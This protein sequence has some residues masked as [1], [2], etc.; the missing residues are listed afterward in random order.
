MFKNTSKRFFFYISLVIAVIIGIAVGLAMVFYSV[1]EYEVL[2]TTINVA[3]TLAVLYNQHHFGDNEMKKKQWQINMGLVEGYDMSSKKYK[4]KDIHATIKKWITMRR[5]HK[6]PILSGSV[7][8]E[9][10]IY[11]YEDGAITEPSAIIK[12]ELSPKFDKHRPDYEVV[13]TLKNL[14]ITLL[15]MHRQNRVYYSYCNV[16][17]TVDKEDLGKYSYRNEIGLLI[18]ESSC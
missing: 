5:K 6:L 12:G 9:M 7:Q 15:Y 10:M 2:F 4:I 13:E 3:V 16:Q 17:Y 8:K 14:A 18:P 11:P 1:T